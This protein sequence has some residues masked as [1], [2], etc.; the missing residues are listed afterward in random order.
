MLAK[1]NQLSFK[2]SSVRIVIAIGFAFVVWLFCTVRLSHRCLAGYKWFE[3]YG[4]FLV[5]AFAGTCFV[6]IRRIWLGVFV[7]LGISFGFFQFAIPGYLAWIHGPNAPRFPALEDEKDRIFN[8]LK[9]IEIPDASGAPM[10]K[11]Q[12]RSNEATISP[13]K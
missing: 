5:G 9:L 10:S 11:A 8:D 13:T 2:S 4:G 7:A 1:H 6:C 3:H 12:D